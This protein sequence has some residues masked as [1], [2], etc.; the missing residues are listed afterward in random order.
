MNETTYT[1]TSSTT[2][3]MLSPEHS[4]R[5]PKH[6]YQSFTTERNWIDLKRIERGEDTRTTV[7]IK[8][9]IILK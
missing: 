4:T 2:S 3:S 9:I 5:K 6:Q 1:V 7:M 8:V